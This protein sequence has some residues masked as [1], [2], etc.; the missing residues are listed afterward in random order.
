MSIHDRIDKRLTNKSN[1][2]AD[3]SDARG[4]EYKPLSIT[5]VEII[6]KNH[7]PSAPEVR[8]GPLSKIL[9]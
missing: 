9:L 4:E 7:C 6:L 2:S 3:Q 1:S 8:T 5:Q